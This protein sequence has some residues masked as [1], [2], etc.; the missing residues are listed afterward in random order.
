MVAV[1]HAVLSSRTITN[2]RWTL[3]IHSQTNNWHNLSV[4]LSVCTV[5]Q[6]TAA[7]RLIDSHNACSQYATDSCSCCWLPCSAAGFAD[8]QFSLRGADMLPMNWLLACHLQLGVRPCST[9]DA[10][11]SNEQHQHHHQ[12]Q[13][14][15]G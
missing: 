6:S 13:Q 4:C 7:V 1:R 12:Q 5:H 15:R 14:Q 9:L 2:V 10:V 3:A 11:R 8:A